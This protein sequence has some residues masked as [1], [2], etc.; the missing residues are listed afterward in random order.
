MVDSETLTYRK[1]RHNSVLST[2]IYVMACL[3]RQVNYDPSETLIDPLW[4]APEKYL[5]RHDEDVDIGQ[6]HGNLAK[7][8]WWLG[9]P[10][11]FDI[12]SVGMSLPQP[13]VGRKKK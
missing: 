10:D 5:Y 2:V 1:A 13:A 4:A 9:S 6:H 12:Y 7:R 3:H 11:K 8:M